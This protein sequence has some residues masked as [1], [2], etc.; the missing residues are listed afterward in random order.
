MRGRGKDTPKYRPHIQRCTCQSRDPPQLR[1]GAAPVSAVS[2]ARLRL[3][4]A[5]FWTGIA[6]DCALSPR[7]LNPGPC[8][9]LP[10]SRSAACLGRAPSRRDWLDRAKRR[11]LSGRTAALPLSIPARTCWHLLG[12]AAAAQANI[13][14]VEAR[15]A[16]RPLPVCWAHRPPSPRAGTGAKSTRYSRSAVS[17]P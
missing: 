7:P 3:T 4:A 11:T 2:S 6:Y 14:F 9:D 16:L 12:N 13:T 15:S 5:V 10:R 17:V 1:D 8:S